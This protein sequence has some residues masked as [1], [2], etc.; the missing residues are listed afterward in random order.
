LN[1]Q[2]ATNRS[3]EGKVPF[4]WNDGA[5]RL[6]NLND[7]DVLMEL[8]FVAK[9]SFSEEDIKVTSDIAGVEAWDGLY[10]KHMIV[11][12]TGKIIKQTDIL[13]YTSESWNVTPNLTQGIINVNVQLVKAKKVH[14]YL[15]DAAGKIV[16][17]QIAQLPTGAS[18]TRF[19]LQRNHRLAAGIYYLKAPGIGSNTAR[20]IILTK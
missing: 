13:L 1:I 5:N 9:G 7:D 17:S 14:F 15:L 10:N 3:N 16:M 18:N 4:I 19:D 8:I 11:K 20:K 2:Y 6:S 12:G